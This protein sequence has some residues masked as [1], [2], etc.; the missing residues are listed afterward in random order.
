MDESSPP[1]LQHLRRQWRDATRE[2][3]AARNE[4]ARLQDGTLVELRAAIAAARRLEQAERRRDAVNRQVEAALEALAQAGGA[5][6]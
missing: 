2:W 3:L 5:S 1:G 4:M 6:G